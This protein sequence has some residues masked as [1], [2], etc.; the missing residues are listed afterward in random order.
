MNEVES[1]IKL[2]AGL[3]W[4]LALI[5]W[6]LVGVES[7]MAADVVLGGNVVFRIS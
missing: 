7:A 2:R 6:G 1:R 3:V 5:L 4:A